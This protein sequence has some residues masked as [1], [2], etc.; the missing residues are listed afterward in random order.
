MP[1]HEKDTDTQEWRL[2]LAFL[3]NSHD[4]LASDSRL[5]VRAHLTGDC[6]SHGSL[7][8]LIELD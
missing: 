2:R 8:R 6:T 7:D 1:P 5:E 4:G 3:D